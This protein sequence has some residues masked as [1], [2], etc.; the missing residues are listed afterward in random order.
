MFYILF[1]RF[2]GMSHKCAFECCN[3]IGVLKS[4]QMKIKLSFLK[5]LFS[6]HTDI[7]IGEANV[8]QKRL[9]V[10]ADPWFL[11]MTRHIVPV[12]PIVVELIEDRKAIF[13]SAALNGLTIVG[14]RFTNT[15]KKPHI[16]FKVEIEFLLAARIIIAFATLCHD[17]RGS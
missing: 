15:K 3:F 16:L 8:S 2:T 7:R 10:L 13:G 5:V 11:V 4:I 14:L 17:I 6:L 12:H 9:V 1:S